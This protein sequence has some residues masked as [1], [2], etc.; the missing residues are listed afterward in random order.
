MFRPAEKN[1]PRK[2]GV[3][4]NNSEGCVTMALSRL[5]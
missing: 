4:S 2:K 1:L 5:H 3:V